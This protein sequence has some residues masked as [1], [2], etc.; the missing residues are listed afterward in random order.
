MEPTTA[1]YAVVNLEFPIFGVDARYRGVERGGPIAPDEADQGYLDFV[2]W[3]NEIDLRGWL[4]DRDRSRHYRDAFLDAGQA[5]ELIAVSSADEIEPTWPLLGYDVWAPGVAPLAWPR[6]R[7]VKVRDSADPV[8]LLEPMQAE[9][10]ARYYSQLN[11]NLLFDT[12]DLANACL[13]A[14]DAMEALAPGLWEGQRL[15]V[16]SVRVDIQDAQR[17]VT[18]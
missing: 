4:T 7:S 1:G 8:A 17:P 6:A 5:V 10:E 9:V 12:A 15:E 3:V 11:H 13:T 16:V 18:R 2:R 14:L